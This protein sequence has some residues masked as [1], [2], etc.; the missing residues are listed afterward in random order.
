[1][2]YSKIE[3]WLLQQRKGSEETGDDMGFGLF[4]KLFNMANKT[5][6]LFKTATDR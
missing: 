2:T 3:F 5:L 1:M 6:S 4:T